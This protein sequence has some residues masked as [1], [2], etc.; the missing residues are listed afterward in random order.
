MKIMNCCVRMKYALV[1]L[2]CLSAFQVNG[3]D[4]EV[5]VFDIPDVESNLVV[6]VVG[7]RKTESIVNGV[8]VPIFTTDT[9]VLGRMDTGVLC[10]V[11]SPKQFAKTFFVLVRQPFE[12]E[13]LWELTPSYKFYEIGHFYK[14]PYSL[15]DL[16]F[17]EGTN[18]Y[19]TAGGGLRLNTGKN[20]HSNAFAT[21]TLETAGD[22][23]RSLAK[24]YY[25]SADE[26][27]AKVELLRPQVAKYEKQMKEINAAMKEEL[28]RRE[29]QG[30]K[31][32]NIY[33][34]DETDKYS[35][36]WKEGRITASLYHDAK[37]EMLN[38]EK[39]LQDFTNR[40]NQNKP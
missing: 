38:A 34:S 3:A 31:T 36:L 28:N 14:I 33:T 10:C 15:E 39:Q 1:I 2:S 6:Q 23:V 5:P 18:L 22:I 9:N 7:F 37:S 24:R 40:T 19:F 20:V 17:G 25:V 8:D 29:K 16:G 13:E 12:R 35:M 21:S 27:R 32:T 26:A 4:A 11:V 30:I